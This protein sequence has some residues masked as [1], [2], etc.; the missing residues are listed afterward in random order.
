MTRYLSSALLLAVG[1]VLAVPAHSTGYLKLDGIEG[2]AADTGR[3]TA[4]DRVRSNEDA[5]PAP[6]LLP[7]IQQVQDQPSSG[8]GE[9]R[10]KG[11]VEYNW[12]VEEGTK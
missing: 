12:K 2:E 7:A 4:P 3:Q 6:L 5:G 8:A 10:R 1:L 11:N 9:A